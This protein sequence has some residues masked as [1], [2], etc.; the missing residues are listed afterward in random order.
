M[1]WRDCTGGGHNAQSIR[2]LLRTIEI[3]IVILGVIVA[4]GVWLLS[5]WLASG[6]LNSG[7]LPVEVVAQ[8]LELMGVVMGLRFIENIYSSSLLGLQRQ[9]TQN[10]V[11]SI[12]A[13]ARGLGAVAILAWVSPTLEAFFLWQALISFL[14]VVW[15]AALIYQMLPAAPRVARFSVPSLVGIWRFAA[16]M[17]G[18]TML[19]ILLTQVDKILLSKMLDL[20]SWV[21]H[22]GDCRR[23]SLVSVY[24]SNI[25]CSISPTDAAADPGGQ[26]R[27]LP[28]ISSGLPVDCG[29]HGNWCDV[30]GVFR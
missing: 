9:V 10:I 20:E 3:I 7:N 17:I 1:R 29:A 5:T 21:L 16:G 2:D 13:T 11:T 12:M 15:F 28:D 30:A 27:S 24:G 4:V 23:V 8:A 18:I 14:T 6:W 26:R 25:E 19:A 22:L